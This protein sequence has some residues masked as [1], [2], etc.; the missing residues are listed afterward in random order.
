MIDAKSF[1]G[2]IKVFYPNYAKLRTAF[3]GRYH[4]YKKQA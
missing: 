1:N 3:T 2:A 4:R